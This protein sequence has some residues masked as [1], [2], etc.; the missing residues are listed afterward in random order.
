[1]D[2]ISESIACIDEANQLDADTIYTLYQ[3]KQCEG[4][5]HY[6]QCINI[7]TITLCGSGSGSNNISV[8]IPE[9]FISC[10]CLRPISFFMA[11]KRY[12][13]VGANDG[14]TVQGRH[15]NVVGKCV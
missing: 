1:M 9:S 3:T 7:T 15:C 6:G 5:A 13:F 10:D 12:P 8:G 11:Q 2:E 4:T 14:A